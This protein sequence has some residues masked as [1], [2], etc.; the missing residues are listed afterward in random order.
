[1]P[2]S[3]GIQAV[4]KRLGQ[5]GLWNKAAGLDKARRE[6]E[7]SPRTLQV[8]LPDELAAEVASAVQ[9]GEFVSESDAVLGAVAE[10][11][12]QRLV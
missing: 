4:C 11:R 8:S 9:R 2:I 5:A 6:R 3:P 1:M 7:V 10:W 12:L